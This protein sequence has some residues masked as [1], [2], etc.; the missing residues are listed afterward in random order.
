[1]LPILSWLFAIFSGLYTLSPI[2]LMP[3]AFLGPFGLG[4]DL[5][6]IIAGVQ[7]IRTAHKAAAEEVVS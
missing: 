7:A 6:A 5:L 3:E 4:D 1:L 2:D